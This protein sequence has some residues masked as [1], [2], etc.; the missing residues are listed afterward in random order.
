MKSFCHAFVCAR[1]FNQISLAEFDFLLGARVGEATNPGPNDFIKHDDFQDDIK[2]VVI[3]PTA[4]HDK[5]KEIFDIDAH[6]YCLAE[7]SATETIQKEMNTVA[8]KNGY[9]CFWSA[10]VHSRQ[11]FDFE[12]PSLRGESLGTCCV[13]NLPNRS[14]PIDFT[15][16][17]L[18]S[19]RLSHNIIRVG[20]LD[21]LVIVFYG[22][23]GYTPESRRANDY[24]L[25]S[26]FQLL[27][28]TRLPTIIAG[29]FNIRPEALP[30]WTLYRDM[31]YVDAFELFEKRWGFQLPPTCNQKTR[32]DTILIPRILQPLV[33]NIQV[34]ENHSFDKHSP[35][36]LVLD[37]PYERPFMEKWHMP[38]SWRDLNV[39]PQL[40]Q[41][42]YLQQVFKQKFEDKIHASDQDFESLLQDWSHIC[43]IAVDGAIVE[44]HAIDP[45]SQPLTGLPMK[46]KGRC[47]ERKEVKVQ[48]QNPVSF[49]QDSYNPKC[50]AFNIKSKQKVKQVRRLQ[51]LL[52]SMKNFFQVSHLPP[53][54][55]RF[56]QWRCEWQSILDGKG[57]GRSWSHW[58]LSFEPIEYVPSTVPKPHWLDVA[59]QLTRHDA[60]LTCQQESVVRNEAFRLR[61]QFDRTDNYMKNTYKM[62]KDKPFPPVSSVETEQTTVGRLRRSRKGSLF[63][64]INDPTIT[65]NREIFFGQACCELAFQKGAILCLAHSSGNVPTKALVSQKKYAMNNSDVSQAF[66]DFWSPFWN[67]DEYDDIVSDKPWESIIDIIDKVP[68]IPEMDLQLENPDVWI[69][70][71]KKLKKGKAAGYDG[72]FADDLKLLPYEAIKHLCCIA[73]RAWDTGFN[74]EYMQART[75]LLAKVEKVKTMSQCRPITIL[76]QIYRLMTKIVAD[77]ILSFWA[78]WLP[79][80]ISGG[81]PGR[82]SRML[83]MAHQ[84]RLEK[85]ILEKDQ[86]GGFVLDL[87]KAF[88]CIPRRPLVHMLSNAGVPVRVLKFWMS[89]LNNLSRLPQLGQSLGGHVFSTTGVPEGDS[90]SVLWNDCFGL[91]FPTTPSLAF[92]SDCGF[93]LRRQLVVDIA[94]DQ[95]KFWCLMANYG[96]H[97][98]HS[99]AN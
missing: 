34:L 91:S 79:S 86:L 12:R 70:T 24:L 71:I 47:I 46:Y 16:D 63:V 44:H 19:S 18:S 68:S 56:L 72:W 87:I 48:I 61:L 85:T 49:S 21:I 69:R 25:A 2:I 58:L 54:Y 74:A 45:V 89:S 60:E 78:S 14:C 41:T 50:V 43:E 88:N 55:D 84:C 65:F 82:G 9:T 37:V 80:T 83:M 3:N 11:I 53:E 98:C 28:E 95:T 31:G 7:T 8:R 67:R 39:E 5:H 29:D 13:T 51:S 35:L 15:E 1:Y 26:A 96:I 42:K 17:V 20:S 38:K 36:R 75:I 94:R 81:I 77:Q 92:Q 64:E 99:N 76:G 40:V 23:T 30:C 90:L 6:C 66:Q 59:L 22:I 33:K 27:T 10:P 57:Y 32:H 93:R 97:K 62:L 4:L 73:S 52:R